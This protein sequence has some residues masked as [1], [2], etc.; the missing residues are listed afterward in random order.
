MLVSLRAGAKLDLYIDASDAAARAA[1][2]QDGKLVECFSKRFS[3]TEQ[4]YSTNEREALALVLSDLHFKYGLICM[5]FTVYTDHVALTNWL[6]NKPA[7]ERHAKWLTKIQDLVF[8]IKKKNIF[9][10]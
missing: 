4:R 6:K 9:A 8:D 7:N 3:K 5:P 2:V 1:L 10:S